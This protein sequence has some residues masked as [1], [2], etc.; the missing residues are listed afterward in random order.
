MGEQ[1]QPPEEQEEEIIEEGQHGGEKGIARE[2]AL[3]HIRKQHPK[4]DIPR[5]DS[6]DIEREA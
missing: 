3:K 4:R 5:V 1:K 2:E 6:S